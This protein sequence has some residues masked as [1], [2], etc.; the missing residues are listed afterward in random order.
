MTSLQ[1]TPVSARTSPLLSY[2]SVIVPGLGQFLSGKRGRGLMIVLT[3]AVLGY[4]LY[5][6]FIEQEIGQVTLGGLTTSWLWLPL[7]LFWAWNVLDAYAASRSRSISMLPGLLLAAVILYVIAWDLTDVRLNRLVERFND[8]RSVAGNLLNPD[9]VTISVNGQDQ[10]C[11]WG[12]MVSYVG[13]RLAGRPPEGLIRLSDNLLDIVGRMK[14]VPASAWQ[15]RLG[16]AAP[17]SRVSNF[18]PSNTRFFG[19]FRA[20]VPNISGKPGVPETLFLNILP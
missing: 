6:S 8:A 4:L 17:G 14:D 15:I 16:L 3:A 5:W 13:D 18:V 19:F 7:A 12:C 20:E 9:A 11:S 2:S 10:I 1:T